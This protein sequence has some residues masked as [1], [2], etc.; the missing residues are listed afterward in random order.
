MSKLSDAK[1]IGGI[2]AILMILTAVPSFGPILGL[3]GIIML[4]IAV[5]KISE[6]TKD[7][8]IFNNFLYFFIITIIG[9]VVAGAILIITFLEAGG[10]S[11]INELQNLA[12]SDPMAVWNTVQP[13]F[14]GVIAAIVVLWILMI[15]SA[16]FLKKSYDKIGDL[17]N[18]KWFKTTGLL[19]LIGAATLIILI[20]FVII[21]IGMI[22][23]IVAFFSI[24]ENLPS[25][26]S[27]N[28]DMSID[29]P[30]G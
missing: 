26:A 14:I 13:L 23:E 10:M 28:Q 16:I 8:S 25:Q 9:I 1:I 27:P 6:E 5:K 24:P 17:T 12:Y 2:G 7:K 15:V 11:Y 22:F 4:F 21:L 18:V 3:V 19:Y 29:Q 30:T 20:G